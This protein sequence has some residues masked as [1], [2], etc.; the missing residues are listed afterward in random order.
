M[1][2]SEELF[3]VALQR[4]HDSTVMPRLTL[5]AMG[6]VQLLAPRP[7]GSYTTTAGRLWSD[8]AAVAETRELFMKLRHLL[9]TPA[10]L[11]ARGLGAAAG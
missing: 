7:R 3:P 1:Y 11:R 9:A 8:E 5:E 6:V 2:E 10:D 4:L